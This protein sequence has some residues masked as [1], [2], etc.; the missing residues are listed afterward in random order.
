MATLT[1]RNVDAPDFSS[2]L[3]GYQTFSKLF[4][5][6][7]GGLSNGLTNF[8]DSQN[9]KANQ[10]VIAAAMRVRDPKAYEAAL[11]SGQFTN[12]VDPRRVTAATYGALNSQASS[13]LSQA[14]QTQQLDD[15]KYASNQ[16]HSLDAAAPVV[17]QAQDLARQGDRAGASALLAT[18]SDK[19]AGAGTKNVMALG[20]NINNAEMFGVDITGKRQDQKFA[21]N[22]D[23]RAG[24]ADQRAQDAAGRD[25]TRFGWEVRDDGDR[26]AGQAAALAVM[27]ESG[28]AQDALAAFGSPKYAK[29]SPGAK[30]MALQQINGTYGNIYSN[31]QLGQ[32]AGYNPGGAAIAGAAGGAQGTNANPWD[33]VLGNGAYGAP[34]TPV[35][36][37]TMGQAYDFGRNTL[38]P[39]TKAAGVGKGADGSVLGSS[40]LGAYQITGQTMQAY[41]QKLYGNKWRD[42]QFTPQVQDNIA[43]KI[44]QEHNGSA[45]ALMSQ[46]SSLDTATAR[47]LVG[48][49]WEQARQVIARGESSGSPQAIVDGLALRAGQE[50]VNKTTPSKLLNAAADDSNVTDVVK[51]L[52]GSD[53]FKGTAAPFLVDNLNDIV[54]RS[55]TSDGKYTLNYAQAGKILSDAL[56]VNHADPQLLD[57]TTWFNNNSIVENL[58]GNSARVNKEGWRVDKGYVDNEIKRAAGGQLARDVDRQRTQT[59]DTAAVSNANARLQQAQAAYVAAQQRKILQPAIDIT[60]YQAQLA[61]AQ[62]AM[63]AVGGTVEG[64]NMPNVQ[65][66]NDSGNVSAPLLTVRRK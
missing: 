13:L 24:H 15:T 37:M 41:G 26:Q 60:R 19:L 17:M 21:A 65:G 57:P 59:V 36:Q 56:T 54:R 33:T 40:A 55:R 39:A 58:R 48:K 14:T 47:S 4:G 43:A 38:I 3:N 2:S 49:P 51:Q 8:D 61:A 9:T 29:L 23:I 66:P 63:R 46:W 34:S 28:N 62:L 7:L 22:T 35:S 53:K 1:W 44:Y 50:N 11:A 64:R 27:N 16:V 10:A 31:A 42:T 45:Q 25:Q 5:D 52:Q 30:M 12:G 32:M 6:A 20:D 18:V